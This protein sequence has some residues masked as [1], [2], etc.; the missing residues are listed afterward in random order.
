MVTRFDGV[1]VT[2]YHH[3]QRLSSEADVGKTVKLDYMRKGQRKTVNLKI[4]ESPDTVTG[5]QPR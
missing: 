4:A 5:T 3:L 2:D 1:N